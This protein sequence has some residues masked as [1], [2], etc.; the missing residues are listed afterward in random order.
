MQ[1]KPKQAKQRNLFIASINYVH[2]FFFHY[3]AWVEREE[4]DGLFCWG[5]GGGGG[6]GRGIP[7]LL[8]LCVSIPEYLINR[9]PN[10][11]SSKSHVK[12]IQLAY[13]TVGTVHV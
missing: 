9:C 5:G 11:T 6:G 13:C 3:S 8:S 10:M 7:G 12:V 1:V 4:R 2:W